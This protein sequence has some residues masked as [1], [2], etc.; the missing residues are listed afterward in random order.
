MREATAAERPRR[1]PEPQGRPR[2]SLLHAA[3]RLGEARAR[4]PPPGPA[5]PRA[6]SRAG[7]AALNEE[8]TAAPLSVNHPVVIRREGRARGGKSRAQPMSRRSAARPAW[9]RR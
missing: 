9:H 3:A 6:A 1:A 7:S 8:V 2:R 5:G 4:R